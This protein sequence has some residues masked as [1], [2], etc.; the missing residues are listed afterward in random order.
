MAECLGHFFPI[1]PNSLLLQIS[2]LSEVIERFQIIRLQLI[3]MYWKGTIVLPPI[4]MKETLSI[5]SKRL[6]FTIDLIDEEACV[7]YM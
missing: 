7:L 6:N 5:W 3:Y 2:N 4:P 1:D